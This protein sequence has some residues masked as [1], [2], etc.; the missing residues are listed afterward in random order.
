M[1][2]EPIWQSI[3]T[4]VDET[5]RARE[6]DPRQ[7]AA[8]GLANQGES[9]IAWD[10]LTGEP[11]YNVITWQCARTAPLCTQIG[12][13]ID[14]AALR[15]K[16]GLILDPYF[17]ATK[18]QW[19]LENVPA[20]QDALRRGSLRLGTL[21]AWMIWRMSGGRLFV[22][23]YTTAARTMLFGVRTLDWEDDL[24]AFFGIPRW[25]LPAPGPSAHVFGKTDPGAF[26]GL[27]VPIAGAAVDQP[28]ALFAQGCRNSGDLKITY[29]TGAFL[30]MNIG[31]QFR[32][33][34]HGLLTSI[35]ASP[36]RAPVQ[37]Y[38]DGGVYSVGA[39]LRWLRDNLGLIADT[40]EITKMAVALDSSEGVYYV[41][42]LAGL[43][44]PHWTR[45]VKAAFLGMTAAT[46]KEHLVRA[47]L[48]SIAFRVFQV[49]RAME[50]DASQE[51]EAIRVDGGVAQNDFLMQFQADLLRIPLH[52]AAAADMTA[53]GAALLAGI[54]VGFWHLDDLA[55][56]HKGDVFVPGRR[57]P[58]PHEA[59]HRWEEAVELAKAFV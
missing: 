29:G 50:A 17:S 24:L 2:P 39:A 23:D 40:R 52:R 28:A 26:L 32:P 56:K 22:T 7:I 3:L 55:R 53:L 42:A 6:I 8:I 15:A 57:A 47:V 11:L 5:L 51:I 38:L 36:A 1:S 37:Y 13:S 31:R 34:S 48:E 9:V 16:T 25:A 18:M 35:A 43:A 59:F 44:A 33:S 4:T 10:G 45:Q 27:R 12:P 30:L 20:V 54:A 49:V 46:I 19:L 21:D 14:A 58:D 41:P